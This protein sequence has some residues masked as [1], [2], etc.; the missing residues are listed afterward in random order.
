MVRPAQSVKSRTPVG[1]CYKASFLRLTI[2][3]LCI[4][5]TGTIAAMGVLRRL[6]LVLSIAGVVYGGPVANKNPAK[7]PI[8][9]APA[10]R[11]ATDK[12]NTLD[13][14]LAVSTPA[15]ETSQNSLN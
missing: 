6:F 3:L 12:L 13:L 15:H 8:K 7:S 5:I 1:T 14:M 9:A 10:P 2:P 11:I 4:V